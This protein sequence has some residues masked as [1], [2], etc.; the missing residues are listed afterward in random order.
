MMPMM[1][2]LIFLAGLLIYGGYGI[3]GLVYPDSYGP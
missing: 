2:I 1:N 3:P